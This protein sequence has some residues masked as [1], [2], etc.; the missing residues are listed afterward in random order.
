MYH[1]CWSDTGSD[2]VIVDTIILQVFFAPVQ[3]EQPTVVDM[4][5]AEQD[6]E[7]AVHEKERVHSSARFCK[8]GSTREGTNLLV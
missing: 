2:K 3:E 8:G 5:D 7:C 1:L 6:L 4:R